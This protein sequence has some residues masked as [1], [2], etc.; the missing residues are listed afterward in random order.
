MVQSTVNSKEITDIILFIILA[1]AGGERC[2]GWCLGSVFEIPIATKCL[3]IT[4]DVRVA[5]AV[6]CTSCKGGTPCAKD[7]HEDGG[8]CELHRDVTVVCL[9]VSNVVIRSAL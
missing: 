5:A 9:I 6:L 2:L 3:G 1:D 8:K 7:K 4:V